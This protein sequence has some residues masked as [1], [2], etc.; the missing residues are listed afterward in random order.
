MALPFTPAPLPG[1]AL[2][3]PSA[4][5]AGHLPPLEQFD[6]AIRLRT[7]LQPAAVS[8][9]VRFL[10]DQGLRV[11]DVDQRNAIVEARGSVMAMSRAFR[12]QLR[13]YAGPDG[14]FR[15]RRGLVHVPRTLVDTIVAVDG[16][17]AR[18]DGSRPR[19]VTSDVRPI[20]I[21][22]RASRTGRPR[23]PVGSDHPAVRSGHPS[24]SP[25]ASAR[26]AAVLRLLPLTAAD[27]AGTGDRAA[28]PGLAR[29]IPL[30]RARTIRRGPL[31]RVVAEQ[32]ERRLARHFLG[33]GVERP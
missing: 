7:P 24:V 3:T 4:P 10:V 29:P 22:L 28:V 6:V 2:P 26:P 31:V 8:A 27:P 25:G 19:P 18:P 21:D 11:L 23:R 16:L 1:S 20:T 5:C 12:V 15:G 14:V 33:T 9:V 32:Q 13:A 30:G 17:D